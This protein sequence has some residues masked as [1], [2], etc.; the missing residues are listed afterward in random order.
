MS[1]VRVYEVAR[2]LDISNRELVQRISAMGIAVRNHM[3]VLEDA[4]VDR[5][6]AALKQK[7]ETK[8]VVEERI[9][10][11]VVRRRA[12][13]PAPEPEVVE[14][15]PEVTEP[16]AAAAD[17]AVA[18]EAGVAG[19]PV[20]SPPSSP[21]LSEGVAADPV[22]S[23]KEASASEGAVES[24]PGASA[25]ESKVSEKE[26]VAD[27]PKSM[28]DVVPPSMGDRGP[29]RRNQG[30]PTS[31]GPAPEP[32][33]VP[34]PP[35]RRAALP[36]GVVTRGDTMAPS[37]Q[38]LSEA[39]KQRIVTE[40]AQQRRVE[41]PRRRE[42]GRAALGPIGRQAGRS[43][44]RPSK[45]R[46]VPGKK[47]KSTEITVP[48]AQKRVIRI[49]DQIQVQ[50]LAQRMSLKSTD[51]LMKLMEMGVGHIHINST[52][53]TD[54]AKII[55]SEF[56]YEVENVARSTEEIVEAA[57]GTFAD[58]EEDRIT[59]APVVTVMGHVDHGKTSLLDRIRRADVA[60]GEA[61]GIT[62]H[63]GA[64][65]VDTPHGPIVF[66]DTP[67]H[68]AF[69]SMR[70]RGASATDVVI[71]VVAADDGVM[72]QTRE[73]INHA[74]AA[75]VPIVVAVNKI[76]RPDSKPEA[77][78]NAMAAEGLQPEEWGGDVIFV[79]CSAVTGTGVEKLLEAVALQS[80]L[81]D[82]RANPGIPGEGV[83]LEAYLDR[84]RGPVANVLVK[85]GTLNAGD[86][87]VVGSAWGRVRAMTD[88]RGKQL[89][90][91]PP[92]TPVEV[93]GLSS[94]PGAGDSLYVVT[95]A[96]RAQSVAESQTGPSAVRP[97]GAPRGLDQIYQMMQSAEVAELKLVVK[98]DVQGTIEALVKSLSELSTEKVKVNV[99][100]TGVGGI[101]END[102]MLATASNAIVIGF[103]VRPA[104]QAK[105]MA[106]KEG[107]EVRTY[108]IIYEALDDVKK[109]MAGL[110]APTI[111]A[112]DLGRAEVRE[113]FHIPKLG[114]IAG[115]YVLDGKIVRNS[116]VR[117]LRDSVQVWEG[118]LGSLR[119]FKDDVKE[120]TTGFECG[121]SLE[122]FSDLKPSDVLECYREKEVAATL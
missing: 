53:D 80:E 54:T 84:G 45:R 33:P 77:I 86:H 71:L 32:E 66:L 105:A 115:C 37:A 18:A 119:R 41:A 13:K 57:R 79:D 8:H 51:L 62:Q 20:A 4:E 101:T 88:D 69:T 112:E 72:P 100:H 90:A 12:K 94:M 103:N 114:M 1:K 6:K 31:R 68:E 47:G 59:R 34:E 95:D 73:A 122:G 30:S 110:L 89:R 104:G 91:A 29:T 21:S 63:I 85:V 25:V 28:A 46:M 102:V 56:G 92:S 70:A 81:L 58:V 14:S 121:I 39:T 48:S 64:Y 74:K 27:E 40:H 82:L 49:E 113:T 60:G 52:L 43:T 93:L 11:T 10:P 107:V 42:L 3:S 50:V 120:V 65:R 38:P 22:S 55:A 5:V 116:K 106:K 117:L 99:I 15:A 7:R 36:P 83:V 35:R 26:P 87:V 67:G 111:V 118:S 23:V 76:D 61:G 97:V 9:R 109:A 78:R 75:G 19:A 96:R 24:V 108:R 98:A 44:G 2:E 17:A 16:V